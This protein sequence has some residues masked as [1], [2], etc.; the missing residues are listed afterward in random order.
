MN[1]TDHFIAGEAV[2]SGYDES[3]LFNPSSAERI[4]TVMHAGA[5]EVDQAIAAARKAFDTWSATG[6]QYRSELMLDIRELIKQHRAE[7]V[8]IVVTEGGKTR[9]DATAE[10]NK[11]VEGIAYAASVPS[12]FQ[13]RQSQNISTSVDTSDSRFPIGVIAAVSPFNFPI[14]I[15]TIQAVMAMACG[16]TVVAKPSERV[17]STFR[18]TA[19]LFGRAGLPDGV[20][21]V[22]NGGKT[23]VER[24]VEHP[25]VA[26]LTFVGST[27]VAKLLHV[28]GAQN[29]KR[30]QAFGS[31]KNH[32]VVL[33]DAD[34]NMAADAAVSAAFGAAGQR[35]MAISVV[36]A[37][38]SI[39]DALV[40][41][42]KK[43][44][45]DIKTGSADGEDVELGPVISAESRDRIH[46]FLA[47]VQG[48]G[49]TLAVDGRQSSG[50][51]CPWL[52]GASLVD[53]VKPGMAIYEEEV[54]GP[55]LSIVRAETYEEAMTIVAGH[56][57]GNGAAIFTRDGG[58]AKRFVES[59]EVGSVGVNVPIPVPNWSHSFGG[60]KAS[61][62]PDTK[63]TGPESLSFYT[64]VKAVTMRWPDPS[65]S[66]VDLGFPTNR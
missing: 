40:D 36:V 19:E 26:G 59:V 9:P 51:G 54:F 16:N 41:Q 61:A 4:G 44:I 50:N 52:V 7:L 62:F 57:M 15:S 53:H 47:G 42:I 20:L 39:G 55:V 33:P 34:L 66:K 27:R 1:V 29:E 17:P 45:P 25:D 30:V 32:M 65:S 48:E 38:G 21:N 24:L 58:I 49:A 8:D 64:R 10:F 56:P 18:R 31:G 63:L 13:N 3:A 60:F 35:C 37:V 46:G 12:W 6:L 43:R 22:V 23:V 11:A 2:Q 28:A 5:N 14:M